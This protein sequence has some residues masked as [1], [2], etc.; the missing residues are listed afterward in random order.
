MAARKQSSP[1]KKTGREQLKGSRTRAAPDESTATLKNVS[2]P[3]EST[4]LSPSNTAITSPSKTNSTLPLTSSC[5]DFVIAGV[6][7]SAGGLDAFKRFFRELPEKTGIAYVLIQ[8]LDPTHDN[9]MVSLL[10][11]YTKMPVVE[12]RDGMRVVANHVYV[13]PPN[14]YVTIQ[15]G[16]LH[17][18][19]PTHRRGMRKPI[20]HFLQSLAIDRRESAIGIILSGTGTDGTVGLQDIKTNGGMAMVQEP[21]TARHESMPRSAVTTGVVDFV[22]AL[23]EM[24]EALVKFVHSARSNRADETGLKDRTPNYLQMILS[25][26]RQRTNH[27]F[28]SYKKA[29]LNRRIQSRMDM[30]HIDEAATY[31]NYLRDSPTEVTQLYKDMLNSVTSFFREPEAWNTIRQDVLPR[32]AQNRKLHRPVRVW[33]PGCASGEEAY[34]MAILLHELAPSL[35]SEGIQIFATDID[36]D[37]LDVARTG[38]YSKNIV[39]NL[40]S[41]RLERFFRKT[42]GGYQVNK[43]LRKSVVVAVQNLISDPPFSQMDLICC[44]NLLIYLEAK[45]Q[46]KIIDLFHFALNESGYLFLGNSESPGPSEDAFEPVSKH[47]RIYRRI[48]P[49]LHG[50]LKS[51]SGSPLAIRPTRTSSHVSALPNTEDYQRLTQQASVNVLASPS[52]LISQQGEILQYYGTTAD[53]LEQP[54]GKPTQNLIRLA[55]KEI[56][57]KVRTAVQNALRSG[58]LI[59][60]KGIRVTQNGKSHT[61]NLQVRPLRPPHSPDGFLLVSFHAADHPAEP[62]RSSQLSVSNI[63]SQSLQQL[64]VEL[65]STREDLQSRIEDLETSNEEVLTVNEELHSANEEL[66]TSKEELQSLNEE[67]NTINHQLQ[68][69]IGELESSNDDLTNLLVSTDIGTLFLD[70]N[71]CIKRYTSSLTKLINLLPEDIG[72]PLADMSL[73]FMDDCLLKDA[74]AVI[75]HLCPIEKEVKAQNA[76]FLRRIIPYR[77]QDDRID[78][79]VVT[80][81]NI[82]EI[83]NANHTV[84]IRERQQAAVARLG[85]RAIQGNGSLQQLF[86]QAVHEVATVLDVEFCR[87][88]ELS[89]DK[90]E[91]LLRAGVGWNPDLMG[92]EE[93]SSGINSQDSFT[94]RSSAPVIVDVLDEEQR[95]FSPK[96]LTDHGVVS[97]MSVI[98]YNRDRPHGVLGAHTT[99]RVNFTQDD[100]NF[101]QAVAHLLTHAIERAHADETIRRS[102]ERLRRMMDTASVGIGFCDSQGSIFQ[103]NDAF[104]HIT[105]YT[106]HELQANRITWLDL[107]GPE[108]A[109]TDNEAMAQLAENG[110]AGPYE[111]E[112]IRRDGTRLP[113]LVS[114]TTLQQN[115][116][117]EHVAFIMDITERKR[118]ELMERELRM[119]EA[120]R[121]IS[122]VS[123]FERRRIGHDLHEQL[124]Q[125]LTG[126]AFAAG[127]IS[128]SLAERDAKEA[129]SASKLVE[130]IDEAL[131]RVQTL[132]RGLMPVEIDAE[133]LTASINGLVE[134]TKDQHLTNCVF[135]CPS[136]VLI[137]DNQAATHLYY[138]AQ[139]A[140]TNAIRHARADEITVSLADSDGLVTLSIRD[141]GHGFHN[142]QHLTGLGIKIMHHRA[143]VIGAS[144]TIDSMVEHG[145][146]VNCIF[147][148]RSNS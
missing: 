57:S 68:G 142:G 2:E 1:R 136:P 111:K 46:R 137:E 76:W 143:N 34:S 64:Q 103:V 52:V 98:I 27:D 40:S 107:T 127:G 61:F 23:E 8:H 25:L 110:I 56:R 126:L 87:I 85:A 78:G 146:Q 115:G 84:H 6:G 140:I 5:D 67:M 38:I 147:N 9:L 45:A 70:N 86:D 83:R 96:L 69:K 133:G 7:A 28:E 63:R 22:L 100:I 21:K 12:I 124:A 81:S 16:R 112:F 3:E 65:V 93:I 62:T 42:A 116:R 131:N 24:P 26:L 145:T 58:A 43:S 129:T 114:I 99:R 118:V 50:Q 130:G 119:A 66:E 53:Y 135:E 19:T 88:L 79:V 51:P 109:D 71:L 122:E 113:I 72:R 77:T 104:L 125:I 108:F 18:T 33:M 14:R 73:Q 15:S 97:G 120:E 11:S 80:F 92:T 29:T 39:D 90:S 47:W 82:T 13:I 54:P 94:L 74:S 148:I 49:R 75:D 144:L 4:D 101:L 117:D 121:A 55:R 89:P 105:G 37:A 134:R 123:N 138:I 139:E 95:F 20:D 41:E 59:D 32:I 10:A 17:L 141:D 31:L 60:T 91:L 30:H 106:R 35:P 44:R 48:G 36:E 128:E 132:A 102:E